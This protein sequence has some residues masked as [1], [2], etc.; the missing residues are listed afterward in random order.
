[1]LD[2]AVAEGVVD[3]MLDG[4]AGEVGLGDEELAVALAE[5]VGGAAEGHGASG[6]IAL[7]AGGGGG[8]HHFAVP[9]TRPFTAFF[10]MALGAGGGAYIGRRTGGEGGCR[11]EQS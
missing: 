7:D 9:G 6:E 3:A 10:G 8:L 1:M 11:R 4:L 2:A 5:L